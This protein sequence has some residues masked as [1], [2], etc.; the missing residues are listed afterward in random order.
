MS[1]NAAHAHPKIHHSAT[2]ANAGERLV[3]LDL[4]SCLQLDD[5]M[6]ATLVDARA[7]ACVFG[8]TLV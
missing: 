4:N 5:A 3:T 8:T 1:Q 6:V 2:Q 7:A